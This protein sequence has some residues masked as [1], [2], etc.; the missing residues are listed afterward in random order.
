MLRLP[1]PRA[2]RMPSCT[3]SGRV[4]SPCRGGQYAP[5]S[6]LRP[7]AQGVSC[8]DEHGPI[9]PFGDKVKGTYLFSLMS[10][11]ILI[12]Y[13]YVPDGDG[14]EG[15]TGALSLLPASALI[16]RRVHSGSYVGTNEIRRARVAG[17]S[18]PHH[19]GGRL[20]RSSGTLAGHFQ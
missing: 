1:I 19:K 9:R 12:R 16:R 8:H 4:A 3:R 6:A 7:A 14:L 20:F 15:M 18:S 11:T 5:T 10:L 2:I 13:F 17:D